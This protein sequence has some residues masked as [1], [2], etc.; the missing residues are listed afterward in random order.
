MNENFNR[1]CKITFEASDKLTRRVAFNFKIV[2][3]RQKK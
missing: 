3:F 2:N 1:F